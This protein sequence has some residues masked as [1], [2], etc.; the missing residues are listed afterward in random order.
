MIGLFLGSLFILMLI[1][2]LI[3]VLFGVIDNCILDMWR[4]EVENLLIF[5]NDVIIEN[6]FER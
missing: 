5:G 1:F 4:V 2:L 3:K 6:N